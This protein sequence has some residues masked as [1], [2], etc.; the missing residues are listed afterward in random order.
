[1]HGR[2]SQTVIKMR[3]RL[4]P[5]HRERA[6]LVATADNSNTVIVANAGAPVLCP[7][8]VAS[9]PILAAQVTVC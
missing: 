1:M 8:R 2:R 6:S 9:I 3:A 5:L 4:E 7:F